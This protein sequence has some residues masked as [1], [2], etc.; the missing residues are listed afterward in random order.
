MSPWGHVRGERTAIQGR[1]SAPFDPTFCP[2]TSALGHCVGGAQRRDR[3]LQL[4]RKTTS[5]TA[6]QYHLS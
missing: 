6:I 2:G 4:E 3:G 1:E 5:M